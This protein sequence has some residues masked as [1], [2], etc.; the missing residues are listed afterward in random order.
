MVQVCHGKQNTAFMTILA[1]AWRLDGENA[2]LAKQKIFSTSSVIPFTWLKLQQKWTW[3]TATYCLFSIQL[4]LFFNAV[5]W[6]G[7]QDHWPSF[8]IIVRW[9]Y[10]NG[11]L[12]VPHEITSTESTKIWDSYNGLYDSF[13]F[14]YH[15]QYFP[16]LVILSF[17]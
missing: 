10:D 9:Y 1:L 6:T 8:Y 5:E 15:N 11:I 16:S 14:F 13:T 4:Y 12:H 17:K 3:L 7:S 2:D